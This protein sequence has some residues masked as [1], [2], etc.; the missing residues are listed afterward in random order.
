MTKHARKPDRGS[1]SRRAFVGGAVGAG[2]VAAGGS[3]ALVGAAVPDSGRSARS[4]AARSPL[5]FG[6][7]FPELPPF[8]EATDDVKAALRELGRPGGIMDANDDL[9][10]GPVALIVDDSLNL[11]NRN[12]TTH[13]AGTT[14]VGQFLDHDVT[15]DA[16]SQLGVPTDPEQTR[17]T[18]VPALDLD[19]VYGGGPSVSPQLYQSDDR[20]KL[21]IES[22]GLFEDVP[23]NA[24]GSA[25][26]ADPRNDENV[27]ISGLQAAF[28][29]FHDNVVDLVRSERL[30]SNTRSTSEVFQEARKQT[31]WHY[32]NM[33]LTQF[34]P[35]IV[36]QTMVDDILRRG[37]SYFRASY[38]GYMPVEFQT[39]T[40]RMGHSMV[41]PSYRVNFTGQPSG[42]PNAPEFFGLIFDPSQ[43]GVSDS[44]DLRGGSRAPRRFIGWPTFFDFGDGNVRPNKIIDTVISTP[45]FQ[46]PLFTIA[47]GEPPTSLPERNLL[48][49]LTWSLP[50]GQTLATTMGVPA[51]SPAEL[52]TTGV[53]DIRSSFLTSTPL[54]F[55]VLHEALVRADGLRLGPVGGRI[56]GEVIIGLLQL[57]RS[58]VL[59]RRRW[60]PLI[61]VRESRRVKMQDILD[62]AG[63]SGLR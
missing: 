33:I 22:G 21:R 45:L 1:I 26:I 6:R 35:Q 47:S 60:R 12:N 11:V 61:P 46:L 9:A 37:R 18:R 17:N 49:H 48:R 19:A 56:V 63:V 7:M 4:G 38:G 54:W 58:S 50:S 8:A 29:K 3:A 42:K 30:V 28:I 31:R 2:V 5:N 34:L 10:A 44:E 51:L 39:G 32:Q 20:A 23:R 40:Y 27:V 55:Y 59:W 24:D 36:G 53:G 25:I 52:G 43:E 13:T 15:F 16:T 57:D 41:R 14:F 62:F